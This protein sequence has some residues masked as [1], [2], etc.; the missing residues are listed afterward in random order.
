MEAFHVQQW[1]LAHQGA[2]QLRVFGCHDAH[3]QTAVAAALC[4]K[5]PDGADPARHQIACDGGKVLGDLVSARPHRLGVPAW[6]V[7]AAAADV[8]QRVGTAVGQPQPTQDTAIAGG[9]G[10]LEAAV[11]A[12]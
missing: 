9:L 8:S 7:L 6:S 1:H 12:Q 4:A 2:E 5:L 11:A 3:Q 10:Y